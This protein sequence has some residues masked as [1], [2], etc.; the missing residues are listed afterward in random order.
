MVVSAKYLDAPRL[1]ATRT[2]VAAGARYLM[3]VFFFLETV[4]AFFSG[5]AYTQSM[6]RLQSVCVTVS[7]RDTWMP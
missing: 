7:Y 1:N 3:F 2:T 4:R 6:Q 5:Q